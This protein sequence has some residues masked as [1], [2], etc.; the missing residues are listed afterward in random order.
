MKKIKI[1]FILLL[2]LLLA[3]GN[4][5]YSQDKFGIGVSAIYN[6]QTESFGA[7]LRVEVGLLRRLSIVPQVMYFPA[8]N[9]VHEIF[10]TVNLHYT[11][12]YLRKFKG[13]VIAGGSANYWIDYA[14]STWERAKPFNVIAEVGGGIAYG[15]KKFRPFIE[16]RYNPVWLE[17]SIHVGLMYYPEIRKRNKET[18]PAYQ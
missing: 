7:G 17:G 3:I 9:K 10:G 15:V 14:E 4:T 6:F 11:V 5:A 13:Y 18:C 1:Q 12:F 8:A 2:P 16:Y